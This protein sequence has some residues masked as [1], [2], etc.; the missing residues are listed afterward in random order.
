MAENDTADIGDDELKADLAAEAAAKAKA[1]ADTK[2]DEGKEV[3]PPKEDDKE[4]VEDD[5]E[6]GDESDSDKKDEEEAP[7]ED[8]DPSKIPVRQSVASQ[9]IA[10]KNR[11]LAKLRS[12]SDDDIEA[13]AEADAE[14]GEEEDEAIDP[15]TQKAIDRAVAPLLD[16]YANKSDEEELQNLFTS[17]PGSKKYEKR[18]RSY[19]KHESYKA[20]PPSMIYHELAFAESQRQGAEKRRVAD[21]EAAQ[22]RPL[23]TSRRPAARKKTG[24]PGDLDIDTMSDADFEALQHDVQTGKYAQ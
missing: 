24:F 14:D 22:N 16:S 13:D 1:D 20:I 5:G 10:R 8:I 7:D 18:I 23:G 21:V 6:E 11:Q 2:S 12:K 15:A 17:E 9:I 4:E 19:M 3:I